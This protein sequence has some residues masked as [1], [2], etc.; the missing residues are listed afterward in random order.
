METNEKQ[1]VQIVYS[2]GTMQQVAPVNIAFIEQTAR[3]IGNYAQ[4]L[5]Q[6]AIINPPEARPTNEE[7][8][9]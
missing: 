7:E 8:Q 2:D 4:R 6:Q 9:E 1:P 3:A 5:K